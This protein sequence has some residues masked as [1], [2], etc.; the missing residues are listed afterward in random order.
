MRLTS[1]FFSMTILISFSLNA[2]ETKNLGELFTNNA[3]KV[4]NT[5]GNK[6]TLGC[7]VNQGAGIVDTLSADQGVGNPINVLTGN[8]FEQATDIQAVGNDYALRLNRYY[9]SRS[10]Q[11]GLF[12][13][14]WR[15]DYEMQLQDTDSTIDIIQADGR[16][17]HFQKTAAALGN[18]SLF[19][20]RYLADKSELGYIERTQSADPSKAAWIWT[21][22]TGK[23]FEFVVHKQVSSVNR[24]GLQRYG[25]LSRVTEQADDPSSPY[26]A[27]TYGVEGELAQVRNHNGDT[28]KFAYERTQGNLPKISVTS[29]TINHNNSNQST[30][31][32]VY[33]LDQNNNLAQVVSPTGVRTGYQYN[34]PHDKHNLTAKFSYNKTKPQLITEW[35]YDAYD[36]AISSS[37]KD[38]V[39]RV[40]VVYDSDT[41]I[42]TQANHVFTNILTNSVGENTDYRYQYTNG[43]AQLLL[44]TGAGCVTCGPANVSYEYD[45]AGRVTKISQLDSQGQSISSIAT[46]FDTLGRVKREINQIAGVLSN[47][48]S[49]TYY[50]YVSNNPSDAGFSLISKQWQ[51]SVAAGKQTGIRYVYDNN[52]LAIE[53]IAFGYTPDGKSL[54]RTF[55]QSYDKNGNV[56]QVALRD[57]N[58]NSKPIIIEAYTWFEDG[59]I[60]TTEQPN[61]NAKTSFTHNDAGLTTQIDRQ[62]G[63]EN[64]TI[65]LSLDNNNLPMSVSR[66][67]NGELL[68]GVKYQRNS[69]GDIINVSDL[70]NNFIASYAYDTAGRN[71]GELTPTSAMLS[72]L[73]TEGRSIVDYSISENNIDKLSYVYDAKSRITGV[74]RDDTQLVSVSYSEDDRAA[75]VVG[76][77]GEHILMQEG[78]SESNEYVLPNI[79]DALGI[80]G[81]TVKTIKSGVT[82]VD[83][84][85][86]ITTDYGVD[87][88]GRIVYID[89]KTAGRNNYRYDARD[90]LI[91]IKM[92]N[93]VKIS[94]Q[95][96]NKGRQV[97]K[98]VTQEGKVVQ[99]V[100]WEFDDKDQ[101]LSVKDN[102]QQIEYQYDD[103]G[104]VTQKCL[105]LADL[106]T[107]LVTSYHYDKDGSMV[108]TTLPDGIKVLSQNNQIRYKAP[109][110]I[111]ATAIYSQSTH[112]AS[113]IN[114][115][116]YQLGQHIV[117]GHFYDDNGQFSGLSYRSI[118]KSG[119]NPFIRS[120]RADDIIPL[121]SQQW[122][123]TSDGIVEQVTE[124]DYQAQPT[125]H[126][127]LY[128]SQYHL[129]TSSY[130]PIEL[131][132]SFTQVSSVNKQTDDQANNDS[133]E[134]RYIYDELGNRILGIDDAQV[135]KKYQYDDK[136]RLTTI[137][138][139]AQTADSPNMNAQTITYD[140]AGLP[141]QYGGYQLSYTAGQLS[142]VK[143]KSG[144]LVAKYTYNDEGQRI[145]KTVYQKD[146]KPLVT[147]EISY[148]VYEDS[149]LQHE[150]DSEGNISRHYVYIGNTLTATLDYPTE[151]HGEV[152][153]S[154]QSDISLWTRGKNWL[155]SLWTQESAYP[156]I[157]YVITDYLGRPRQVRDGETNA[158]KWQFTPTAFG[159]QVDTS[160][161]VNKSDSSYE[162]N[163]R[164]PGQYEDTE[165]G[166][167]YNHWR[168]YD[169]GTGRYLSADPLGLGGG[170]NLYAY[171]NATPTH[172]IDPP[173]LLLFAFDGTGNQDYGSN[174]RSNVVK[175]RDAYKADPNEPNMFKN[176]IHTIDDQSRR[177]GSFANKN[178]F[179]ISGAAT[180]DQYSGI[181]APLGDGGFGLSIVKRV[182]KMVE[183]LHSYL[184]YVEDNYTGKDK[185]KKAINIDLDIVGFSRGAASARM[186]ASKVTK[187]MET[188]EWYTYGQATNGNPHRKRTQPWK[189]TNAWLKNNC[190]VNFNFNF[191]GLWDTVPSYGGSLDNDVSDLNNF[192]MSLSIPDRFKKVVHAVAVNEHRAHF[193]GRSMFDNQA[194]ANRYA[195]SANRVE[196]GFLG[197]HSDIGGGYGEGDL[198][199]V[200]LMWVIQEAKKAGIDFNDTLIAKKGW[201]NVTD[202]IVHDSVGV[203]LS[204]INFMPG[205]E[206]RWVGSDV[207]MFDGRQQFERF[208]HLKFNWRDSLE[209]Q[210]KNTQGEVLRRFEDI[211]RWTREYNRVDQ[212]ST[213]H[214]V[215]GEVVMCDETEEIVDLKETGAEGNP[216]ILYKYMQIKDY[217]AWLK[218]NGYGLSNLKVKGK[219]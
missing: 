135:L 1:L 74:G 154:D 56:I 37:H 9:N 35:Q 14:G 3:S 118:P 25:Q 129:I 140:A 82:R 142:Q 76:A 17:I 145:K 202:P 4:C 125:E 29:S 62:I 146:N 130:Q 214:P 141:T 48:Q 204:G 150:L 200:S 90:Q 109:D 77:S 197:A 38:G 171:V 217:I 139:V 160:I 187:I 206:F 162:L 207:E 100:T 201:N 7:P 22:P 101:L 205:R 21:L 92:A 11:R 63:T 182:D 87:D 106:A 39:E 215:C 161:N 183:Y 45:S 33:F 41:V 24:L 216:T 67:L 79:W 34:D 195:H 113:S 46:E 169:K 144:K 209:F 49:T 166:L 184:E 192:G 175:F 13:I 27:L 57:D 156:T 133:I 70:D 136:G 61:L 55:L 174:E 8:K 178:A 176:G 69:K 18:S 124:L 164:F 185:P 99:Q 170:E 71:L 20:T 5:N 53:K 199:D 173:G 44:V 188:G 168:Y 143:D 59:S 28:L 159:G 10:S 212:T 72:R 6:G 138:P 155:G 15:H 119:D 210:S 108:G 88:F 153:S 149:Q 186:F 179:Y 51:A 93:G 122:Q 181:E 80:K 180:D 120:A 85:D 132:N 115:T 42:P 134:A 157:N 83:Q 218:N 36:R 52:G 193:H 32:W 114:Q 81:T 91:G 58:A 43:E 75:E 127:Y 177:F 84:N 68:N 128:D 89:S 123:R 73:D 107:P 152:L 148:Y 131:D 64:T 126:N 147:P 211:E 163:V 97:S 102:N 189:Y 191:M 19:V 50:E 137:T 60:K 2:A 116:S 117:M 112:Q 213:G 16:Q 194:Q 208:A 96:D 190:N 23:Q 98:E 158:L 105:S 111:R 12:G 198:S 94:Y 167:Y 121:F 103:Q 95:Y 110:D 31:R 196:R 66:Y 172:F 40:S 86:D 104:R 165:T 54:S 47:K 151:Q 30:G 203:E 65:K 26:W 219:S 78:S